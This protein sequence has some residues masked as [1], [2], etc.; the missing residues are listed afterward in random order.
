MLRLASTS[1]PAHRDA[2]GVA[3]T[4]GCGRVTRTAGPATFFVAQP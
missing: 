4:P 3:G 2:L 1:L